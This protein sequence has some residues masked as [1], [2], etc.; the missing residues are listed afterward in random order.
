M[1]IYFYQT[2]PL[3][4]PILMPTPEQQIAESILQCMLGEIQPEDRRALMEDYV[5][6]SP[7]NRQTFETLSRPETLR[8]KLQQ[9]YAAGRDGREADE[10]PGEGVDANGKGAISLPILAVGPALCRPYFPHVEKK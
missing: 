9:F 8:R 4:V 3:P 1:R 6:Q 10:A 2:M 7:H 5:Q